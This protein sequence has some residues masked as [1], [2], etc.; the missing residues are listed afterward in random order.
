[1]AE[2]DLVIVES[3]TKAK[4]IAKILG[5]KYRVEA[6][7]GHVRDLPKSKLGVDVEGDFMPDYVIPTASRKTV[8]KLKELA[9]KAEHIYLATDE[10]R[11]GEA[12]GWHVQAVLKA[13]DNKISRVAFHEITPEAIKEAFQHTRNLD[14]HLVD[15]QQARRVLD[16][17]VGYKLS[18]LLWRKIFRRL[19]A[20]RVQS[21]ALRLLVEREREIEA[22]RPEEYWSIGVEFETPKGEKLTAAVS[23]V[24]GKEP[25]LVDGV[26]SAAVVKILEQAS[27][28]RVTSIKE[29]TRERHPAAP[30]TTSTLQQQA[31]I[32]LGFSVK[33]TMTIAQ[34][35]YEGIDVGQGQVG[36]ITYM[37]TDSTN[38]AMSAIQTAR[39]TIEEMYGK[40]F[41]PDKPRFYKTKSRGAQEAHEAIRP[42]NPALTPDMVRAKL[43]NDQWRLYRLIWQR[44]VAC[45]MKSAILKTREILVDS[46]T[47]TS[48]ANGATVVFTGFAKVFD[49]WPFQENVLPD[50]AEKDLLKLLGVTPSQHFTEPPARY[51][52][53][54]LVKQMEKMGIGRPSTYAPTIV[55]LGVRGY[56]KKEKRSLIPQAVG[57]MVN[58]FLVEHFPNIVDYNFTARMEDD[59]DDIAEGKKEW[60]PVIKEFYGPFIKQ[61]EMKDKEVVKQTAE[62][63][64]TDKL[65]IKCNSPMVIK[66]GRFG[67]FMACSGFPECKY[68]EPLDGHGKSTVEATDKICSKCNSPMV[69]KVG[70]FGP[71]YGCSNYP[72][73]KNIENIEAPTIDMACPKCKEGRVVTRRTKRGKVFWGCSNYPKCDF[74]SWDEPVDHV[75]PTC[76]AAMTKPA[77]KG[78][79]VCTG[80]GFE[81][82]DA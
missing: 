30:F 59:L 21:V 34:R 37:R 67:K 45:Q 80:C 50:M 75:C 32:Q 46:D 39:K 35:L 13:P 60:V 65:C 82:K 47:V 4:T 76:G 12:I 51:T 15:A 66:T 14:L 71:F 48:Q 68:T 64:A 26:S 1:M 62:D 42:A 44:M 10:D 81:E 43:D 77:K 8:T 58:D 78:Y 74:A 61:I 38:L 52:E 70:R 53:P 16:R 29:E 7:Y 18:P 57:M 20:G 17:L 28:H 72:T 27:E 6:S 31:G 49:K 40:E 54:A 22:F 19:S 24:N 11:E 55:T 63:E 73:C 33:K 9:S 79:P 41:L 25:G 23:K 69:R 2:K 56:V 3:P 36:L 5:T